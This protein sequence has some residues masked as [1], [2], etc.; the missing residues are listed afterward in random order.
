[1]LSPQL[2]QILAASPTLRRILS[3]YTVN[4]LGSWLGLIALSLAVFDHT[5]SA[6]A[7][8]LLLFAWQALPAFVVPAV[9]ARV[10]ASTRRHE[11]SGLYGIEAAATAAIAILLA[12][13]SLPGI[14][15]LAVV[16]G[17]A[18]LAASS[19]LRTEAARC[20][21]EALVDPTAI[22]DSARPS[23]DAVDAAENQVTA[24]V[25]I[26]LAATFV[27]GPVVGGA[28]TAGL[29][30]APALLIDAVSFAICAALLIDLDPHVEG[31]AAS[32][33]ISRLTEGWRHIGRLPTLRMLLSGAALALLFIQAGGPIEVAYAKTSLHAGDGGYGLLVSA[34][35]VGGLL[36]GLLFAR[37]SHTKSTALLVVGVLAQAVALMGYALAPTL[38]VACVAA[39]VG[40]VGNFLEFPA[41]TSLAGRLTPIALKGR[42]MGTVESLSSLCAA[43]GLVLGGVI[44]TVT[45]PRAAFAIVGVAVAGSSV[46]FIRLAAA[47]VEPPDVGDDTVARVSAQGVD[48]SGVG[49]GRPAGTCDRDT[50][51]VARD[52]AH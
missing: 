16:D 15:F 21:R 42:M 52:A 27:V 17:T 3:A 51:R 10:E 43:G 11:L 5:H 2:R 49:S 30:A 48:T 4:R 20:G 40:G 18:A 38:P 1:V 36:G 33:V 34:Q 28:A 24:V 7:V 29:G 41:L 26:A 37:I 39:V 12:H 44:V 14:L 50:Q 23:Q 47:G 32:S 31:A 19:L 25:A 8:A 35:G 6:L 22:D 13:F 9:V 45:S 46:I